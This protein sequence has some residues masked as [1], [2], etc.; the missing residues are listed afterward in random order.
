MSWQSA[1]RDKVRGLIAYFKHSSDEP[2][3]VAPTEDDLMR[4]TMAS[5]LSRVSV[6]RVGQSYILEIGYNSIDPRKAALAANAIAAAYIRTGLTERAS[7]A[8]SGAKWLETRLIEVGRQAREAAM[9]VEEFRAKN[10]IM[11]IELLLLARP[12]AIVGDQQP[13]AGGPGTERRPNP[14]SL[15]RSTV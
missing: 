8:Q 4:R 12:A 11:E 14:P 5:F 13:G 1:L 6:N 10:G 3:K 2:V 9:S 15:R 7:A